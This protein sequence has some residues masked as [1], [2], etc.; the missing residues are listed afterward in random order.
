MDP[1]PARYPPAMD[2]RIALVCA[3]CGPVFLVLFVAGFWFVAGL[4]PPPRPSDN[5]AQIAA[6]YRDNTDR[7][8]VGMLMSMVATALLA[9][10]I[11]LITQQM[12]RRNPRLALLADIQLLCGFA[13]LIMILI[14][15]P[16]VTAAAQR[17]RVLRP[18]LGLLDAGPRVPVDGRLLADGPQRPAAVPA[19]GRVVRPRHRR[20]LRDRRAG[21]LRQGRSLRL[22]RAARVLGRPAHLRRLGPRLLRL[23]APRSPD[24]RDLRPLSPMR[25]R[26]PSGL[27]ARCASTR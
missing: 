27:R 12:K 24:D 13:L 5:A 1:G 16:R 14:P 23:R 17:H 7:I 15:S 11:I 6:F 22:E 25:C 3:W 2:R 8:R 4:V 26:R 19:L 10:F 20:D 18:L 9:P 21:P